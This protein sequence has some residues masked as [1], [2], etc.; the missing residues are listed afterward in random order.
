MRNVEISNFHPG[1]T[2]APLIQHGFT[3]YIRIGATFKGNNMLN[4]SAF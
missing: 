4:N 3:M 2:D 1:V